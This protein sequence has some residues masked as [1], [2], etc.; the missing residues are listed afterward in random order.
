MCTV[1]LETGW[2]ESTSRLRPAQVLQKLRSASRS[3]VVPDSGTKTGSRSTQCVM[4]QQS[5]SGSS[6]APSG[7]ELAAAIR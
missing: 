5:A 6:T 4:G 3:Y 2:L 1:S 7:T